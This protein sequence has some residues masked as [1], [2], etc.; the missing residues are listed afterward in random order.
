MPEKTN[1]ENNCQE[2]GIFSPVAGV[3]E[4]FKQM[5]Y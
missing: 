3:L 4:R 5:K 2:E 1:D